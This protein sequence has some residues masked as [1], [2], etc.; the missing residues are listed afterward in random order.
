MMPLGTCVQSLLSELK[1]SAGATGTAIKTHREK[2]EGI[3]VS[4]PWLQQLDKQMTK[5]ARTEAATEGTQVDH[6]DRSDDG[7]GE[8]ADEQWHDHTTVIEA[9]KSARRD[10][11]QKREL[12]ISLF[13]IS[14]LGGQWQIQRTGRSVYGL[15]V[16]VVKN[17]IVDELSNVWHVRKSASFEYN[18]YSREGAE[19]LVEAWMDRMQFVAAVWDAHGRS[20]LVFPAKCHDVFVYAPEIQDR[21]MSLTERSRSRLAQFAL[22]WPSSTA[23]QGQ[24]SSSHTNSAEPVV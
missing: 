3:N 15:R 6:E 4:R 2:P 5:R 22:I 11:E 23:A 8:E 1:P 21:F 10:I 17:T 7:D 14:L 19:I 12:R 16:D 24:A 9:V 20:S 18:V 13:K